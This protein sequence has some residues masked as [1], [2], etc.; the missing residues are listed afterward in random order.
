MDLLGFL[1]RACQSLRR[2]HGEHGLLFVKDNTDSSEYVIADQQQF[3]RTESHY[4]SIFKEAGFEMLEQLRQ[5]FPD[6]EAKDLLTV[7]MWVLRP[8]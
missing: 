8:E 3:I 4:S 1:K 2:D 7:S 5:K 6:V